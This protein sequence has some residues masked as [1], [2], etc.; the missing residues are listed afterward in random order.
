MKDFLVALVVIL[1]YFLLITAFLAGSVWL[2][3]KIF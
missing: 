3:T 1:W 2:M